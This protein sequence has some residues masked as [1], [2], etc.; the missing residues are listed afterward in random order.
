MILPH[1]HIAPSLIPGAGKGLFLDEPVAR[2]ALITAPDDIRRVYR[3]DEVNALPNAAELLPAT[4]RW[5]QDYY[6]ISDDWPD[7]CY[8]NHAFAP[9]GLWH[10][11]FVFAM[12]VLP[13]GTEITVDYRHLLAPGQE[14]D[15]R[16][17]LSGEK[18]IGYSWAES[19]G[20]S[21]RQLSELLR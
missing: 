11:G 6:T 17:A 10:L 3:W 4:V 16:D 13:I 2:G 7:E 21:T 14:E 9:S 12:Q 15:F 18:I 20:H 1:Y 19:L 5:F 8:I